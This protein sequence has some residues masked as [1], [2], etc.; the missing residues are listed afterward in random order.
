MKKC[1]LEQF[2][3]GDPEGII[4]IYLVKIQ[5]YY[6]DHVIK[7]NQIDYECLEFIISRGYYKVALS[8]YENYFLLNHI[9]IT[10]K[11]VYKLLLF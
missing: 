5:I 6:E 2:T 3:I 7:N 8:L 9:D 10:E 11:I 4:F 1:Y